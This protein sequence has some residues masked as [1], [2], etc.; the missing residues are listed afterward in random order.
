MNQPALNQTQ[1]SQYSK[2]PAKFRLSQMTVREL[3]D[4]I[5]SAADFTQVKTCLLVHGKAHDEQ[6]AKELITAWV[7][8]LC[9]GA[10]T[11]TKA[12]LMF[13]GPVDDAF[14]AA[15]LCTRWYEEFCDTFIGCFVHHDPVPPN[16]VT[17]TEITAAIHGTLMLLKNKW[18][19]DLHPQL[20]AWVDAEDSG[21]LQPTSV[22]CVG[23][24]YSD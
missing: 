14:H 6:E 22:S 24:G 10:T 20:S 3:Y 2:V 16:T 23:N 8:W 5:M 7:Q 18:G 1:V 4:Q 13:H 11:N 19:N 15:I 12:Y 9:V 17:D 21:T